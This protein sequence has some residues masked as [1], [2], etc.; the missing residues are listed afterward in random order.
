MREGGKHCCSG[1]NWTRGDV[2]R[3][4]VAFHFSI[5]DSKT[6]SRNFR[7]RAMK[8]TEK[9]K[10]RDC[11]VKLGYGKKKIKLQTLWEE[12]VVALGDL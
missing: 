11:Q 10:G 1:G 6:T 2:Y 7:E 4:L 5:G 12:N 9:T 8:A 3:G